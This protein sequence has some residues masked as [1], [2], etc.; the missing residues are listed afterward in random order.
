MH[1][2]EGIFGKF[3]NKARA[4]GSAGQTRRWMNKTKLILWLNFTWGIFLIDSFLSS[5]FFFLVL[6]GG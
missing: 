6:E 2:P 3:W 1:V 4:Q 5:L